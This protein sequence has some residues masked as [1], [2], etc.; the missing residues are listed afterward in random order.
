MPTKLISFLLAALMLTMALFCP[1]EAWASSWYCVGKTCGE[2]AWVCCREIATEKNQV[3]QLSQRSSLSSRRINVCRSSQSGEK[4][5]CTMVE[6]SATS[7][8]IA[9]PSAMFIPETTFLSLMQ[10]VLPTTPT[11]NTP[12]HTTEGRGPP[13]KTSACTSLG[14]R[15]PP[16]L[17]AY[18]PLS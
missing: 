13:G 10:M 5:D 15:A 3:C 4:C 11:I 16:A 1:K 17:N 8:T 9:N 14:L 7:R 6:K 2:R 12:S 18:F